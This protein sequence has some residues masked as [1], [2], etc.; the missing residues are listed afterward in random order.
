MG[1]LNSNDYKNFKGIDDINEHY[2]SLNLARTNSK[3]EAAETERVKSFTELF[4][5]KYLEKRV[6]TYFFYPSIYSYILSGYLDS[7]MLEAE[8]KKR[9]PEVIPKEI[10]DFRTLLNYKFRELSDE[11]YVKLAKNVLQNAKEGKYQIYDY[12]QIANFFYFFTKNNLITESKEEIDKIIMQGLEISKARKQINDG[13]IENL[14]HFEDDNPDVTEMKKIVK[15]IHDEIK[16]EEYVADSNELI[17]CLTDKDEFALARIF[18]KH[19]FS[20]VLFQYID[21]KLLLDAILGISNKQLFNFTELLRHRY[22]IRNIGE[23]IFEDTICLTKLKN[24]FSAYLAKTKNIQQPR[25]FLYATLETSLMDTIQ[26][27]NDTRK[28]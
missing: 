16:K 8:I 24:N 19:K 5:E 11:D 3:S 27:L 22:E 12:V 25:L 26:H 10:L 18:E 17:D 4:Y 13:I 15:G 2:Y 28:K 20:K 21:D 1:F 14:L 6:K 9:Y 7:N 23:F